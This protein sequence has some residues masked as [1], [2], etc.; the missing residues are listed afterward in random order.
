MDKYSKNATYNELVDFSIS[1]GLRADL[2]QAAGGNV[3]LKDD[4]ENIFV[5]RSGLSLKEASS[6]DIF[7]KLNYLTNKE[8]VLKAL[9]NNEEDLE[10]NLPSHDQQPSIETSFHIFFS[11]RI[12][13]HVHAINIIV[14]TI[15]KKYR[16]VILNII[17]DQPILY[18]PYCKPGFS[19]TK[20]IHSL[21][22]RVGI[23]PEVVILE[24]HGIIVLG[25]NFNEINSRLDSVLS[26]CA[27]KTRALKSEF[28]NNEFKWI[29][30]FKQLLNFKL[31]RLPLIHELARDE[32]NLSIIKL[33]ALYP[34]HVVY[35]NEKYLILPFNDDVSNLNYV[36]SNVAFISTFCI[37][38][39]PNHGILVN[40][41]ITHAQEE[42]LEC[43]FNVVDRIPHNSEVSTLNDIEI[44][45]LNTWEAEKY[46]QKISGANIID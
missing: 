37:L 34:D 26:I 40:K 35:L 24:N 1:I 31:P 21:V 25:D 46:R 6:K 23:Y 39:I 2:V 7:T 5:K 8:K 42:M 10:M 9:E 33:N 19:I 15:V 43:W 28:S 27:C 30:D 3:S 16:D 44:E 18:V 4:F 22:R 17:S 36:K 41:N 38:I 20:N 13:V 29:S 12:V 11:D 14:W 32:F 45:E